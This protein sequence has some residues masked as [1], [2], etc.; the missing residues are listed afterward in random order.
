MKI[1]IMEFTRGGQ[2]TFYRVK[3]QFDWWTE[4]EYADA[5]P[6]VNFST[7]AAATDAAFAIRVEDNRVKDRI[8]VNLLDEYGDRLR[9][10]E[11][12]HLGFQ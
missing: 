6:G 12:E 8:H 9:P 3:Y 1:V 4:W 2:E 11:V 5:N 10:C 7:K